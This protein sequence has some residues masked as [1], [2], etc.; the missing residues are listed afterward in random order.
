MQEAV[1]CFPHSLGRNDQRCS[2]WCWQPQHSA[3]CVVNLHVGD[4]REGAVCV[5][6]RAMHLLRSCLAV[7]E[8][9]KQLWLYPAALDWL[10]VAWETTSAHDL[11]L[12]T[13]KGVQ[14]TQI[15]VQARYTMQQYKSVDQ[16][17][18]NNSSTSESVWISKNLFAGAVNVLY[19][20]APMRPS[21]TCDFVIPE[22]PCRCLRGPSG[23]QEESDRWWPLGPG[24]NYRNK[25]KDWSFQTSPKDIEIY[26]SYER[27][28]D[29]IIPGNIAFKRHNR[30][31]WPDHL[32]AMNASLSSLNEV[33][34]H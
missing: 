14:T 29:L 10:P 1:T 9:S 24:I 33:H 4:D 26:K 6:R 25:R 2:E 19:Q 11:H 13:T 22:E 34:A 8:R 30:W 31:I 16:N 27:Q 28:Y 5:G 3:S 17:T 20:V 12:R 15:G 23:P 21:F 32:A 7:A 18:L